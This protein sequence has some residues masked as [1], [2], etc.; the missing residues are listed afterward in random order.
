MNR[1]GIDVGSKTVKLVVLDLPFVQE[2]VATIQ[3]VQAAIPKD[4]IA[5]G[6]HLLRNAWFG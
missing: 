3:A 1:I 5:E 6:V 4:R 2:V